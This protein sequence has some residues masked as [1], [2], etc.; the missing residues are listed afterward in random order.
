MELVVATRNQHKL[1]EIKTLLKNLPIEVFSLDSFK[2]VPEVVE[3]GK[4]MEENAIKKA[5]QTSKFLKR[6]VIADDSGLEVDALNGRPGVFSARFSGKGATYESNNIKLLNLLK[7]TPLNKR[8]ATFRCIIAIADNGK[9]IGLAEGRCHGKV[10]FYP[11]GKNGF[12]YDPVFIPS[13]YK[14][15]FAQ[16]SP[17]EKNKISH[18]GKALA[19][20]K[21]LILKYL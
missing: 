15:S 5:I 9:M 7:D 19:K 6:I 21:Q 3:D 18:R 10:G 20:A 4:T 16:L 17:L 8:K 1:Y 11:K 14:K 13:G 12:G 2:N